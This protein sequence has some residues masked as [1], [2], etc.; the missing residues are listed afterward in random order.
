MIRNTVIF[1]AALFVMSSCA[2]NNNFKTTQTFAPAKFQV[3]DVYVNMAG[4]IENS[5]RVRK[6][7]K[8]AGA[9]TANVYNDTM[10][11]ARS[12]YPL[13]IEVTELNYRNP[14]ASATSGDRTYIR[15][16]ATLREEASGAVYRALPVTY[17]HVSAGLLESSEAKQN[18]EKNMI[19]LSIKN[20]FARLYGLESVSQNVQT[21]FTTN[22]IF[23][24]P[25]AVSA[26][27]VVTRAK[28]IVAKPITPAPTAA[29]VTTTPEVIVAPD[30]AIIESTTTEDGVTVLKCAVC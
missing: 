27:P 3:A 10:Q 26:K 15:Y 4:G 1:S 8:N 13:E 20:A 22:D 6:L 12:I 16:T 28:P 9:N 25:E 24:S 5:N 2:S 19:R 29:P 18:A 30:E 11:S 21:P 14:K 17:Y 7:M 23:A